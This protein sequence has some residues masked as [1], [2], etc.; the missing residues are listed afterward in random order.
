MEMLRRF[1]AFSVAVLAF[2]VPAFAQ[3]PAP[4]AAAP[5]TRIDVK[6]L[7]T[8]TGPKRPLRYTVAPGTKDRIDMT[9]QMGVSVEMPGMGAQEMAGPAM[10][11]GIDVDV[12]SVAPNGDIN[13]TQKISEATMDGPGMP[14]GMLDSIKGLAIA[15]VVDSRGLVKTMNIDDSKL[16]DPALKQV[17]ASAGLDRL[18][19]P[20]PEEPVGLGAKWQ[21]SQS[22]E[23]QGIKLDQLSEFEV[24]AMDDKSA[25]LALTLTQTAPPQ[26]V[27]P[28]GMPAG[29]EASI[30]GMNGTG[31]GKLV[32]TPGT[33]VMTGD[34]N[35]KSNIT[36]D[37][38]MQGQSQRMTT[39]TDMKMSIARGQRQ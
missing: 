13:F 14:A 34:M 35:V 19:T 26:T 10:K 29:V 1:A 30:A 23:T 18:S 16:G 5:I 33:L 9:M 21:V 36:M 12:A 4:A 20:L 27:S 11:M 32:L 24:V 17:L 37:I 31:T 6:V 39:S 28:P 8:G 3:T 15:M 25:T 38:N 22:L 2:A 7:S